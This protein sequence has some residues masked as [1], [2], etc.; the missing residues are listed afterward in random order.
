MLLTANEWEFFM[1][2]GEDIGVDM[3]SKVV[4]WV[5]DKVRKWL[6]R[7]REVIDGVEKLIR[8]EDREAVKARM[9]LVLGRWLE[10]EEGFQRWIRL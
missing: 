3:S 2:S 8:K 4:E 1:S 5:R 10:L 9:E 7:A 6:I